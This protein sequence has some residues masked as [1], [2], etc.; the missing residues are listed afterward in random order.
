MIA[1]VNPRFA[2]LSVNCILDSKNTMYLV[3]RISILSVNSL[4]T[5]CALTACFHRSS[6]YSRTEDIRRRDFLT[7]LLFPFGESVLTLA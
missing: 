2:T 1:R 6:S 7:L 4:S 3:C 5:F